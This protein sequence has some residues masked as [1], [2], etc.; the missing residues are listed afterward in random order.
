MRLQL[1]LEKEKQTILYSCHYIMIAVL[2]VN[3]YRSLVARSIC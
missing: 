3:V 2:M 1:R